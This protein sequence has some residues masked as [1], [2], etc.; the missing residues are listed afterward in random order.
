MA[1]SW[2]RIGWVGCI[3]LLAAGCWNTKPSVKPPPHP[4]EFKLPP[5]D[6]ARFSK[7]LEYPKGALNQD[8]IR[9]KGSTGADPSDPMGAPG[10]SAVGGGLGPGGL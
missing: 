2:R 8:F 6:D 9:K 1:A 7:P 10:R 5:E 3:L 4:D